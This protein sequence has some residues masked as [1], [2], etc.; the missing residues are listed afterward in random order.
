MFKP[1]SCDF[2][3]SRNR[4]VSR[5]TALRIKKSWFVCL[6]SPQNSTKYIG[7]FVFVNSYVYFYSVHKD[8]CYFHCI[9]ITLF[10]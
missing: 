2:D 8:T 9:I 6:I 1:L 4:V 5:L 10:V 3:I 7:F